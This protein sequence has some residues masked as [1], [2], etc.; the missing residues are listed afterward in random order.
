MRALDRLIG[1]RIVALPE[2]IDSA[3]WPKGALVFRLAADEVLVTAEVGAAAI[4]D[5]H[6][7]VELETGFSS[8]WLP[9]DAA[10][11]FL[12]REC[13]WEL[14]RGVRQW[15]N[16]PGVYRAAFAQGLVAGLPVKV[17]FERDRVLLIVASPF[18]MDLMERLR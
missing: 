15:G 13:D 9:P 5:P 16:D 4:G 10:I 8:V 12:E 7:I 11:D 18:A 3:V 6:A 1:T 2:A 14:P 17:W